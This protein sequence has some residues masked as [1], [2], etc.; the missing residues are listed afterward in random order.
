MASGA[1]SSLDALAPVTPAVSTAVDDELGEAF[2]AFATF[3][4]FSAFTAATS[5]A[6][7]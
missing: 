2:A 6:S 4:A 1:A 5:A 7:E 3:A